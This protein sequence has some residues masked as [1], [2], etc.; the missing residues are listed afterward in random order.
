MAAP[1][2]HQMSLQE[3]AEETGMTVGAVNV[4]LGR[5]LKKLRSQGLILTARRAVWI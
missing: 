3:I 1:I 5:A 2:K 4:C